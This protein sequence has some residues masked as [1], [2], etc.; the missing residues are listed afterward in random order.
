MALD[1]PDLKL[2]DYSVWRNYTRKCTSMHR[3]YGRPITISKSE[4]EIKLDQVRLM[5]LHY[6]ANVSCLVRQLFV[7][8]LGVSTL[9]LKK[10]PTFKLSVTFSNVSRFSKLQ[11]CWKAYEICYKTMTSLPH[12][13]HVATIPWEIKNFNICIYSAQMGE[14]ASILHSS[15]L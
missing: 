13:R 11:Q 7:I 4:M 15:P 8:G 1:L 5:L 9:C 14:N 6:F 2:V 10:V 3:R 12:L